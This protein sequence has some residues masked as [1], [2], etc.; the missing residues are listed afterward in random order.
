MNACAMYDETNDQCAS[1]LASKTT[2][3]CRGRSEKYP[4]EYKTIF[5]QDDVMPELVLE[6]STKIWQEILAN[7]KG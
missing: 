2:M 3:L 1:G 4:T 6:R 5:C 7:S